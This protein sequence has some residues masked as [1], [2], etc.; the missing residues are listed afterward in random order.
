MAMNRIKLIIAGSVLV[1]ALLA[2]VSYLQ[3]V[4]PGIRL[5]DGE[6]REYDGAPLSS[7][8]DFRENS[9]RGPQH[10]DRDSYRLTVTGLVD[11]ALSLPYVDLLADYPRYEKV[12]TLH[13][14]E[15]WSVTI[16]W[17]GILVADVLAAAGVDPQA[18]TVI[19]TA[20]DGY[21]TSL[22]LA[23]LLDNE[24]LMA[25]TMNGV[26]LPPE[27]GFPLQLVAEHKLGYK[28][29]KWLTAI[30]LSDDTT[31]RGY[32]ERRGYSNDADVP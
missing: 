3:R 23:Y 18:D 12:V 28:W 27:R 15:G 8:R 25:H 21:T 1:I 7:I 30:D 32:W 9:I 31:Y 16:L 22:P 14:V 6:V 19:F 24:I 10:V 2:S 4:N 29:I 11:H 5:P 13:C 17:E 26:V 20:A